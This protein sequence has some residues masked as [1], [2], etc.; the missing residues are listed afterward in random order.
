MLFNSYIFLLLFFP[1]VLVGWWS[2]ASLPRTR[3]FALVAA[4][5]VFYGWKD[6]EFT[7]LLLISTVVDYFLGAQMAE[8]KSQLR[9]RLLLGM[10]LATNLG[11]LGYFKYR[12][13]FAESIN[14]VLDALQ[15]GS[16]VDVPTVFLPIGISFYTFQTL[17]YSLDIYRREV[18]PAKSILHFA[19]YVSMFPQLIAGP[20]VRYRDIELQLDELEPQIPWEKIANG[21]WFF[22]LGLAQKLLVADIIASSINPILEHPDKLD[23]L[24]GNFALFGYTAQL[25]FDFSGYSNMA[26]GIGLM[27]GFQFPQNFDSPYKARDI[28]DFWR[29]W[30]MTLSTFLRDYLYIPLGGNRVGKL[31]SLRNLVIVMFLGGLWHGAAW[32]FVMWGLYH[33]MLLAGYAM[34]RSLQLP[35]FPRAVAIAITFLFVAYGWLLFRSNDLQ[36]IQS[37]TQAILGLSTIS[38]PAIDITA[39]ASVFLATVLL[40]CWLLP[41]VWEMKKPLSYGHACLGAILLWFCVLRFDADSPFLYFQF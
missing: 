41:N 36:M 7:F 28:Q 39:K 25:Y 38:T 16:F 15:T 22:I 26:V 17:S 12:G 11:L 35:R 18:K 13:M 14:A 5:Y 24:S 27:L 19:A 6:W 34:V 31:L 3:L 9:L 2:L 20:I 1:L 8:E 30:H 10:S 40:A 21:A 32:T 29:R 33:G 37:W 4:S 23:F